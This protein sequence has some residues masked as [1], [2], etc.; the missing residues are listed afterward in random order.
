MDKD[1]DVRLDAIFVLG[2]KMANRVSDSLHRGNALVYVYQWAK[3]ANDD[4]ETQDLVP[5]MYLY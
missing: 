2:D 4:N 3:S 5:L 1:P